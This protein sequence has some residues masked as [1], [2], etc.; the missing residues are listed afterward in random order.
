MLR[1]KHLLALVI[2]SVACF[3]APAQ[4]IREYMDLQVHPT[5][6]VPYSFFGKGMTWFDEAHPPKLKYKH[7]LKNISYANYFNHNKG[8][9]IMVAGVLT[10]ENMWSRKKA[11]RILVK[12]LKYYD[13]FVMN[14]SDNFAIAKTPQEVRDLV[15]TTDKI[16]IVFSIEGGRNL[17]DSQEDANFW[18]EKGVSFITLV[19]L[20]DSKYGASAIRPGLGTTMLNSKGVFRR[21]KNRRLTE[22]GKQAIQWLANAGVMTDLTHMSDLTRKDALAFM[23]E[24]G[25]PP[26]VTHDMFKPIQNHPRG[27]EEEDVIKIYRNNGLMSLPL[28]GESLMAFKPSEKY[29]AKIDSLT[30]YCNGS[31]DSYI[32]SYL[33]L[34]EFIENN[35]AA[36]SGNSNLKLKDLDEKELV[37]ISIGF[38]SDF[39]GWVNHHRPRYGKDGCYE[40]V[41]GMSYEDIEVEG[42]AH[43]G[44]MD[45]HWKLMVKEGV[46]IEPV[47]RASEKFLQMWQQFLDR[48]GTF[49]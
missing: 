48:R 34:K 14:N 12:Q 9:R 25:I 3:N 38:Q 11:R 40:L 26:L 4:E 43:P 24:K 20:V 21:E 45:S 1:C 27:V 42:L 32:F 5:M 41:P 19:H 39:N 6:H 29:K 16:I 37:N 46:D 8:L 47:K 15:H 36:I 13:E 33:A 49:D 23:E 7:F 10:R 22:K 31:I 2:T 18:A 35:L 44:L 30:R 17:V 28:S